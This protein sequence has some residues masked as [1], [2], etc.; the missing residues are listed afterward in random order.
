MKQSKKTIV[1]S[2]VCAVLA[3]CAISLI[4]SSLL[5][6][7][8]PNQTETTTSKRLS[9]TSTTAGKTTGRLLQD[10]TA[11]EITTTKR[12][13]LTAYTGR[14]TTTQ[15]ETTKATK[16]T[17]TTTVRKTTRTATGQEKQTI[18]DYVYYKNIAALAE[19]ER[20]IS[21]LETEISDLQ[22]QASS[23]YSDYKQQELALK[24]RYASMGMLNSGAYKNAVDNLYRQYTTN[25]ATISEKLAD[26]K[27]EREQA[28]EN[29]KLLEQQTEEKI[30]TEFA[31]ELE[32][33][34]Q[35][36]LS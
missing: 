20:N 22:K 26:L 25:L 17:T 21:R 8:V 30:Y 5:I 1:L 35:S 14:R 12:I 10:K 23:L 11:G 36:T 24:E 16:P 18:Y 4:L 6:E 9:T 2:I 34:Q 13:W 15:R 27:E 28:E 19:Y 33:F 32:K 7:H 31:E 3:V 29:Y